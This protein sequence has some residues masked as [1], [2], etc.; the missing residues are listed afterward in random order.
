MDRRREIWGEVGRFGEKRFG[1]KK[2]EDGRKKTEI[3]KERV[4][5]RQD[6]KKTKTEHFVLEN[7]PLI[8][9]R[10]SQEILP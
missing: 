10:I 2:G 9:S 7:S 1:E 6:G 4:E 5:E 8:I 3:G